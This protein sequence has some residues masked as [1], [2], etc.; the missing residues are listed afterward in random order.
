MKQETQHFY[1]LLGRGVT[2]DHDELRIQNWTIVLGQAHHYLKR[3]ASRPGHVTAHKD[4][5]RGVDV[6][7]VNANL[8]DHRGHDAEGADAGTE[9]ESISRVDTTSQF[10]EELLASSGGHPKTS[11]VASTSGSSRWLAR[12]IMVKGRF[13]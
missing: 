6:L 4:I 11:D 9:S 10:V 12:Y 1:S 8:V 3:A 2:R 13:L 7:I 5:L